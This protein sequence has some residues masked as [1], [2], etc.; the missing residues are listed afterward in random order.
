MPDRLAEAMVTAVRGD[1][2]AGRHILRD[3]WKN[4]PGDFALPIQWIGQLYFTDHN[5]PQALSYLDSALQVDPNSV[6]PLYLKGCAYY[7]FH[8]TASLAP[9]VEQLADK[10]PWLT[11]P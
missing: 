5:I 1:S 7:V 4:G 2:E 11:I 8:D 6:I 10:A 3:I 9:V